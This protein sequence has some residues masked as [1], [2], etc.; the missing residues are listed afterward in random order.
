MLKVPYPD[1][2][3]KLVTQDAAKLGHT[4]GTLD[5]Y[6]EVEKRLSEFD[7]LAEHTP[8]QWDSVRDEYEMLRQLQEQ[9]MSPL[10]PI[11]A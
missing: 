10:Q 3:N 4:G 7:A 11:A 8:E 2:Y 9:L 6:V 1:E 5:L